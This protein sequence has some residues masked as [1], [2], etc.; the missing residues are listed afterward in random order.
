MKTNTS[1][2]VFNKYTDENKNVIF[3]KHLIDNVFWDDSKGI[4][5]N[6]GYENAD[7]VNVFI[8]KNKNDMSGYVEPK[9]YKGL[10]NTWTLENGD[11]IVKGNVEESSVM[12]IKE[13]LKKYDNVF[14]ISLVDDKD[15]GSANMQHFEIRGK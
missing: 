1:M 13:L 8:P 15:F 6:L 12:S 3:K 5:R 9:K 10:N 14:T 2:S 11:F 7:D 4:N